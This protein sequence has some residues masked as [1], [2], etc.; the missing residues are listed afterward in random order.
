MKYADAMI[1]WE[2][3]GA[4]KVGPWPD[5][6]GWSEAFP[7]TS[8]ACYA[9]VRKMTGWQAVA[10]ML[11]DFHAVVVRD[12]VSPQAAH[13]AFLAIDEYRARISPDIAGAA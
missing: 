13:E 11:L 5:T 3:N 2:P 8:G 7:L 10:M 4:I 12:G 9:E 6:A 1:A